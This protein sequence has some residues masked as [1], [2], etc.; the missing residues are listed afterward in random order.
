MVPQATAN[1][2]PGNAVLQQGHRSAWLFLEKQ[3][4]PSSSA[5]RY[6]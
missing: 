2:Q 5:A 4:R 3:H 6:V 1:N